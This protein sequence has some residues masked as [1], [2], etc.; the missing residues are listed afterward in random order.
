MLT[1]TELRK[2]AKARLRDAESLLRARRYDGAAYLCGYTVEMALK[3]RI[4][5]T[6]QWREFPSTR[7]EFKGL[8][9]FRT[10][11]L[12]ILLRLSGAER[13][14]NRKFL[15]EWSAVANWDPEARYKPAGKVSK[16][17]AQLMIDSAR[18]LLGAL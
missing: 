6:L 10:H 11:A 7:G 14:I 16:Q 5:Q 18:T 2:I 15:A 4:C 12:G 3:A 8:E 17:D 9:S 13:N 1:R